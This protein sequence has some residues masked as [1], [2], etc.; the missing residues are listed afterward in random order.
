[1]LVPIYCEVYTA[2]KF[3]LIFFSEEINDV[4]IKLWIS[5]TPLYK[6]ILN[7]KKY[8]ANTDITSKS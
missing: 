1:M 5:C 7:T 6:F 8:K 3:I 2:A 4:I